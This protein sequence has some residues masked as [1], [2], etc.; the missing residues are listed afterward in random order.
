MVL[1]IPGTYFWLPLVY[2]HGH[3]RVIELSQAFTA[4]RYYKN[5][6]LAASHMLLKTVPT[7]SAP[8]HGK[9]IFFKM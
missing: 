6:V 7:P 5:D 9:V 1:Y 3:A 8:N 2:L 4:P